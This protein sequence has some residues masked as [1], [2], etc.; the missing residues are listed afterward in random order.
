MCCEVSQHADELACGF[1]VCKTPFTSESFALE[2]TANYTNCS[3]Q[4]DG[5]SK[6]E[7]AVRTTITRNL[8]PRKAKKNLL[9]GKPADKVGPSQGRKTKALAKL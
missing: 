2:H 9:T 7:N 5:Y 3:S 8:R 1:E 4:Q 6:L